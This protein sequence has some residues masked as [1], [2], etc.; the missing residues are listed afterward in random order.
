MQLP[1]PYGRQAGRVGANPESG[2]TMRQGSVPAGR[3]VHIDTGPSVADTA[4]FVEHGPELLAQ[5]ANCVIVAARRGGEA[6]GG[7][8]ARVVPHPHHWLELRRYRGHP[9]QRAAAGA[10]RVWRRSA[11]PVRGVGR[12]ARR[13]P[14]LERGAAG[15]C[16][17]Q[18]GGVALQPDSTRSAPI[19]HGPERPSWGPR[20]NHTARVR[21]PLSLGCQSWSIS[22]TPCSSGR[23]PC[24]SPVRSASVPRPLRSRLSRDGHTRSSIAD[25]RRPPRR[26]ADVGG[27]VRVPL[28]PPTARRPPTR[29]APW[30]ATEGAA[31]P[32]PSRPR[33]ASAP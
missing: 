6:G 31:R 4:T 10:C 16:T 9:P 26:S 19:Q 1:W 5:S 33:R 14:V 27:P 3:I 12:K 18:A 17:G 11:H 15:R 25:V 20:L 22:I 8:A 30:P 13:A 7:R 29:S 32:P 23:R 21:L 24:S 2:C 28:T